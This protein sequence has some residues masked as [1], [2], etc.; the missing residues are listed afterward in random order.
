MGSAQ[1]YDIGPAVPRPVVDPPQ[2]RGVYFTSLGLPFALTS[3]HRMVGPFSVP[4]GVPRQ[5]IVDGLHDLLDVVDP[6][7]RTLTLL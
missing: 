3:A 6:L 2:G 4:N 7:L 5:L 1:K